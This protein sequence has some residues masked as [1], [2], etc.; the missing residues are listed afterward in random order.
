MNGIHE[1]RGSTPLSSTK[2]KQIKP[3]GLN[4]RLYYVEEAIEDG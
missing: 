3:V 1:A 2:K 4:P